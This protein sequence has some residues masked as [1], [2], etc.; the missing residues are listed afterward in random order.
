MQTKGNEITYVFLQFMVGK[1]SKIVP[2]WFSP[3]VVW[4]KVVKRQEK[5]H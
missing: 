2:N 5:N 4:E 1:A 3:A